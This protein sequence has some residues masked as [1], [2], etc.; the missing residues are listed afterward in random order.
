MI[1]EP[2]MTQNISPFNLQTSENWH[3]YYKM[4]TP[5]TQMPENWLSMHAS[6]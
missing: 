4:Q 3:Y 2:Q 1:A 5:K 6:K